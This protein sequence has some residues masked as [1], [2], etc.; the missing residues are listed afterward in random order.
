MKYLFISAGP[1][2]ASAYHTLLLCGFH[3][4]L[5]YCIDIYEEN[6]GYVRVIY[7]LY[8]RLC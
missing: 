1:D 4:Q 8:M 5:N 2:F 6:Y 3:G 7:M